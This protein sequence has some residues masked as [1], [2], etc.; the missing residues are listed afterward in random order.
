MCVF[1]VLGPDA[2]T[3]RI[4]L[5]NFNVNTRPFHDY[6]HAEDHKLSNCDMTSGFKLFTTFTDKIRLGPQ[7][8]LFVHV[9]LGH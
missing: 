1:S 7:S 5:Y 3:C 4:D 2:T 6:T 9:S 8:L